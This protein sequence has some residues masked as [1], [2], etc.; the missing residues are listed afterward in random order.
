MWCIPSVNYVYINVTS[1]ITPVF[2]C[3]I[4]YASSYPYILADAPPRLFDVH[5]KSLAAYP[6]QPG[7]GEREAIHGSDDRNVPF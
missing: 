2:M 5:G 7:G 1:A 6:G 4:S 3:D